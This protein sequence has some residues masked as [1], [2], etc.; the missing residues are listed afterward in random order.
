MAQRRVRHLT[1][2][3]EPAVKVFPSFL[4]NYIRP[5]DA[6]LSLPSPALDLLPLPPVPLGAP[7]GPGQGS[8]GL[9]GPL[10]PSLSKVANLIYLDVSSNSF[11][12]EDSSS[13]TAARQQE[14]YVS[15]MKDHVNGGFEW[16]LCQWAWFGLSS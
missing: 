6:Q 2:K 7:Y 9:T 10:T 11:E 1:Y 8:K 12:G 4:S 13:M 16:G 3:Q 15:C 5:H 14:P